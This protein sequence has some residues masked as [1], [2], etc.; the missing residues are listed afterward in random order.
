MNEIN[1]DKKMYM[2]FLE[3]IKKLEPNKKEIKIEKYILTFKYATVR[4]NLGEIYDEVNFTAISSK[5]T[6]SDLA[7]IIMIE[8]WVHGL[9]KDYVTTVELYKNDDGTFKMCLY[10]DRPKESID[11]FLN[12]I[13]DEISK[14]D[15]TK[16][17]EIIHKLNDVINYL[18]EEYDKATDQGE[19]EYTV[20]TNEMLENVIKPL[21]DVKTYL[22]RGGKNT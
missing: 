10:S 13:Y 17:K 3:K 19:D 12:A 8:F 11:E 1:I 21:G 14:T 18:T 4:V 2:W 9:H 6:G 5:A 20:Y 15:T 22:I 16:S 7:N